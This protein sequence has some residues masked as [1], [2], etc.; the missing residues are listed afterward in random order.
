M[1]L[2][3]FQLAQNARGSPSKRLPVGAFELAAAA[4][5]LVVHPPASAWRQASAHVLSV[6]DKEMGKG[7]GQ[8]MGKGRLASLC[9]AVMTLGPVRVLAPALAGC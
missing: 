6:T 4:L 5:V 7:Q 8:E 1:L 9:L 2:L 3:P